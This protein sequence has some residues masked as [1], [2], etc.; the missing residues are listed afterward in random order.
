MA[1]E[2]LDAKA[3][4]F[5]ARMDLSICILT[6]CQPDLLPKCVASGFA[7]IDKAGISGEVI[8]VDNAS[9]D[10]SPRGLSETFPSIRL[11]RNDENLSFSTANNEAIRVSRG[12]HVLILNDDAILKDGCLGLMLRRLEAEPKTGAVGPMLL[13]PDGSLQA[14][15]TNKRFPT[16]HGVLI[17]FLPFC[18][19]FFRNRLTRNFL[20]DC[21]DARRSGEADHIAGA[22]LLVRRAALDAVGLFDDGFHYWFEDVD[23]CYRLKKAGWRIDYLAEAR[24]LHYGSASFRKVGGRPEQAA[25]YYTSLVRF[26]RKHS[27]RAR[28]NAFRAFL[29]PAFICRIPVAA[30]YGMWKRGP[31]FAEVSGAVRT[32]WVVLRSMFS[33]DRTNASDPGAS[34]AVEPAGR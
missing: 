15:F 11:I 21:K 14:G 13:N 31:R 4:A 22:C 27:S 30:L 1:V 29:A 12:R 16:I 8:V 3:P 5:S 10:G 25:M 9:T 28:Y 18:K 24:V 23:L 2:L 32:S 19:V 26:L 17:E 34:S 33:R 6:H 20:T 7:E